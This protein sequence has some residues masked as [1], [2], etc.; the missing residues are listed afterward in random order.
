[1][2]VVR[3]EMTMS[4]LEMDMNVTS[5]MTDSEVTTDR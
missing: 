2:I 3:K 1:M 5:S 4:V